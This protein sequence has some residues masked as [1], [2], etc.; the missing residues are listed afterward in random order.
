MTWDEVLM[1]RIDYRYI[2]PNDIREIYEAN[3]DAYD[4]EA[5]CRACDEE[6]DELISEHFKPFESQKPMEPDH[7]VYYRMKRGEFDK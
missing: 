4:L 5:L 7:F 6:S 3:P 1:P 2:L